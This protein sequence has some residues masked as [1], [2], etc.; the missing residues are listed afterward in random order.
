MDFSQLL[1]DKSQTITD[2]WIEAVRSDRQIQSADDLSR[3]AIQNH[4][5]DVLRAM[6]T[7]LA[8]YQESDI[9]TLVEASLEHGVLRAGQGFEPIEIAREYR[10]LRQVTFSTLEEDLKQASSIDVIRA[11]RLIDAVVDEAIAQCFKSYMEQRLGELQQLQSQLQLNNQEL[12]RLVRANQESLSH[13][14]H[15][16]K[17]PLTSIIGYSELFLRQQRNKDQVNDN[18]RN[19]EHID[20]VLWGGRQLLRLIN[21]TLEISR[22]EAGKMK[23][24]P[25][26][27]N[28]RSLINSVIEMVQ[29]L[30]NSK[31]LQMIVECDSATAD[32]SATLREGLRPTAAPDQVF[33][34]PLRLQQIITNLLSNA[35]RYTETGSIKLT[36]QTV[37]QEEWA[38]AIADTGIGIE[39][40]DQI[41]IFEP[42]F[43]AGSS[44]QSYHPHSTGLGLAIVSRLVKLLQGKMELVSEIGIGSTF[45]VIFPLEVQI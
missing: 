37:S 8:K 45:T 26:S 41:R 31:Q 32:S 23:L 28:V 34:D 43:Q 24:Q 38:I 13:L 2:K 39:P 3:T 20:K 1:I 12:T 7:V 35:I 11:V 44:Q 27:T 21:D 14:A 18:L 30:A 33:T 16:L 36:C 4:L 40:E 29:P 9:N 22:Y 6:A 42:Y 25:S 15:E 10:L 17:T 19:L 5:P